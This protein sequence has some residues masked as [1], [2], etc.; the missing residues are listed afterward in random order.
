MLLILAALLLAAL[1]PVFAQ[2]NAPEAG[3][4]LRFY[5]TGLNDIDRV[6]IPLD[7]PETAVDVGG[8]FTIEFFLRA[9]PEEVTSGGCV[10]GE[11]GWTNGNIIFDRD[12]FGGGDY[13]DYGISLFGA[14]GVIA[15]GASIGGAGDTI[16]GTV[17]V[18]DGQWHHIAVTRSGETGRLALYIDGL[19]DGT[20]TSAAGDISY[21]DG[22]GTDWRNDPFIVI[23]AEKHDYSPQYPSFSGWFDE[24]RISDVIRYAEDEAFDPPTEPF[25]P[26]EN[27]LGL[28]HF[29]EGEGE[30][31]DDSSGTDSHG[32]LM[33][34]GDPA[35]PEWVTETPFTD[36]E[37]A[38]TPEATAETPTG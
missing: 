25:E 6:K 2:E 17:D 24:L 10:G 29:D 22:R 7:D 5:G 13:G 28:Y 8:D 14:G 38:A 23:G 15:F 27:T 35:G 11:A 18:T 34:G 16:C 19:L 36:L 31:V 20:T 9:L 4:A 37:E 3:F 12:V 26:D 30:T 21:R 32:Q 33:V 1:P